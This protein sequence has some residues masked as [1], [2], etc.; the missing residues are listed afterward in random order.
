MQ[1]RAWNLSNL[2]S[3]YLRAHLMGLFRLKST[4]SK[5]EAVVVLFRSWRGISG[6]SNDNL[7]FSLEAS[8]CYEAATESNKMIMAPPFCDKNGGKD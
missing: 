5:P 8:E 1:L 7:D 2:A 6:K 3:V 4:S